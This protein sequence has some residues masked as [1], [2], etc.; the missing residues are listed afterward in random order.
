MLDITGAGAQ[1]PM[2][3][4]WKLRPGGP[5][6]HKNSEQQ[7]KRCRA[8]T[9]SNNTSAT[10][11]TQS[12]QAAKK[13]ALRGKRPSSRSLLPLSPPCSH[14]ITAPPRGTSDNNNNNNNKQKPRGTDGE[15]QSTLW[16]CAP[17]VRTLASAPPWFSGTPLK[18]PQITSERRIPGA[19]TGRGS[20]PY[21][22]DAPPLSE[23]LALAPPWLSRPSAV[24]RLLEA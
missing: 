14:P 18:A 16:S 10:G 20:P 24:A 7:Y 17:P 22:H 11:Q 5:Q 1:P 6:S 12:P 15:G 23:P 8:N 19:L 13:Q 4:H 21:G 3:S 9:A 2:R